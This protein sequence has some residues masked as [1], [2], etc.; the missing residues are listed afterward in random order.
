MLH[1]ACCLLRRLLLGSGKYLA[2]CW[3]SSGLVVCSKIVCLLVWAHCNL[4]HL[5]FAGD[6]GCSFSHYKFIIAI[7]TVPHNQTHPMT[8]EI[9]NLVWRLQRRRRT[10]PVAELQ[11]RH[12]VDTPHPASDNTGRTRWKISMIALRLR[13][14]VFAVCCMYQGTTSRL[15]SGK[16][17]D[18]VNGVR[19]GR[20]T[21]AIY[22]AGSLVEC[23]LLCV[24]DKSCSDFNFGSGQCEIVSSTTPCR[25]NAP[26]W[27][28]GYYPTSKYQT[29]VTGR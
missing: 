26:G 11:S 3:L 19:Y 16:T 13:W 27:S 10:L 6:L 7:F 29:S 15:I 23:A 12:T 2:G 18:L 28:H 9:Q 4:G 1:L 5:T 20:G 22:R 17:F 25:T 14:L 8:T 24:Q 21:P